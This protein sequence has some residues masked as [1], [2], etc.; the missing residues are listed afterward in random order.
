MSGKPCSITVLYKCWVL[1]IHSS[2]KLLSLHT[3]SGPTQLEILQSS[4][5]IIQIALPLDKEQYQDVNPSKNYFSIELLFVRPVLL[6]TETSF[7]VIMPNLFD[8]R[9]SSWQ[10]WVSWVCVL[11]IGARLVLKN[12]C[13]YNLSHSYKHTLYLK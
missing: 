1:L 10:I 8:L 4:E 12:F 3:F 2:C 6:K 5:E 9:S 11:V 7:L 13:K